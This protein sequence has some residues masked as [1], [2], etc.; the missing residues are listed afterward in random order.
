MVV[1][2]FPC[3]WSE[4]GARHCEKR[5]QSERQDQQGD[6]QPT[7]D[8]GRQ[9]RRWV[10]F[11]A[12]IAVSDKPRAD[13][14]HHAN[15][16]WGARA[17]SVPRLCSAFLAGNDAQSCASRLVSSSTSWRHSVWHTCDYWRSRSLKWFCIAR[18]LWRAA[19]CVRPCRRSTLGWDFFPQWSGQTLTPLRQTP[20]LHGRK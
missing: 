16:H 5:A 3:K 14:R 2:T 15:Y 10:L 9:L 6:F 13:A 18:R 7:S 12:R 8:C 11:N 20:I 4:S 17:I 1:A 19:R